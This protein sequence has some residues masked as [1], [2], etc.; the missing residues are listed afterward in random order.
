MMTES[1]GAAVTIRAAE[2]R[3]APVL[4]RLIHDM[5]AYEGQA[6]VCRVTEPALRGAL[7]GPRPLTEAIVAEDGSGTI[8]FAFIFSYFVPYS[9]VPG[10]FMELLYVTAARRG[11]GI[12]RALLQRVAQ[13]AVERGAERLEWGVLKENAPA[14]GFYT[15]LGAKFAEDFI[16]GRLDGET[17]R[18]V[19]A[20]E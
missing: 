19:A 7:F 2:E 6:D 14:I 13:I 3:D 12:G 5:A 16:A 17:L 11:Q 10:L 20:G 9:G 1:I 15:H 8:G 18:R 4:L